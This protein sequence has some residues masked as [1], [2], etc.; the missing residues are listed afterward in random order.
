VIYRVEILVNQCAHNNVLW[1][2]V[3]DCVVFFLVAFASDMQAETGLASYYI[4]FASLT[5]PGRHPPNNPSSAMEI[6]Q[7]QKD[8]CPPGKAGQS[9]QDDHILVAHGDLRE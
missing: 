4:A 7:R 1:L 3:P 6:D 8:V 5:C 9:G 2:W